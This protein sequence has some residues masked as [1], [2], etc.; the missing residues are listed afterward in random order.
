[1][2]CGPG[3][4]GETVTRPLTPVAAIA[5]ALVSKRIPADVA[6]F[7]MPESYAETPVQSHVNV[8]T[9]HPAVRNDVPAG[10]RML[11]AAF[12]RV[13]GSFLEQR[14][15]IADSHPRRRPVLIRNEPARVAEM[16]TTTTPSWQ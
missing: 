7:I 1:M 5:L 14:R 13:Q 9:T 4:A 2:R 8:W 12:I 10:Q 6:K 11:H 3:C 15:R 16:A